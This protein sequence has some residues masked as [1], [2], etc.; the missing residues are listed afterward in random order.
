MGLCSAPKIPDPNESYVAGVR[1]D[2][3]T[4]PA[5]RQIE[6]L[7][8]TGGKGVVRINGR[9]IPVD[10]TG[11]GEAQYQ[12][13]Y[14]DKMAEQLL[15][16]Q[17]E[18]GPEYVQQRL[19][20]LQRSDPEGFAMRQTLWDRIRGQVEENQNAARPQ[21]N[22]LERYVMGEL[23]KGAT[24]DP[25]MEHDLS[26]R[27]QGGQVARGN[28]LGNAA[29]SQEAGALAGAGEEMRSRREQMALQFLTSGVSAADVQERRGQQD[30]ANL[31]AFVNNETPQAQFGQ[32]SG[33]QQGAVPW[34]PQGGTL[35][36]VNPNAGAQGM[37]F[38]NGL[39]AGQVNWQNSQVNP[40]LAGL[41]GGMQGVNLWA[42]LGGGQA[43]P[44]PQFNLPQAPA[45]NVG[46]DAAP[47]NW[48]NVA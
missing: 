7:A 45:A 34:N 4:L 29:A 33:A 12:G 32:V 20:E 43:A 19:T 6:A 38:A 5:R 8:Q 48:G 35:P 17:R 21:A 24:L 46:F 30:L 42:N 44:P 27:V 40:W 9:D 28:W 31:G 41:S 11:L 23:D 25:R 26:Q 47:N 2:L 14:A 10:F 36:G 15:A 13:Q 22:E 39:Y 3:D 18:L 37:N 16:L 1:A